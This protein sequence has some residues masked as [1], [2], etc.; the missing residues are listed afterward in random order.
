M[1]A[2][3]S[4]G[5]GSTR[6]TPSIFLS[7]RRTARLQEAQV[8][9]STGMMTFDSPTAALAACGALPAALA[10]TTATIPRAEAAIRTTR[11]WLMALPRSCTL[12]STN[13]SGMVPQAGRSS[14]LDLDAGKNR[15]LQRLVEGMV[16]E[17][18]VERL[19]VAPRFHQAV[20]LELGQVLRDRGH[21]H[22][23]N[24]GD[25][26]DADLLH[27]GEQPGDAQAG[28]TS[29]DREPR[30]ELVNLGRE[31]HLLAQLGDVLRSQ[32]GSHAFH[33]STLTIAHA[34]VSRS[35]ASCAGW[36]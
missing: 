11:R 13:E 2:S 10:G 19:R 35:S 23:E 27:L 26:A 25:V 15:L 9:P 33:G 8:S 14:R 12:A 20:R 16:G 5:P 36:R 22:T 4:C 17:R 3:F 7:A 21:G 32:R 6:L 29:G 30:R 1:R 31:L 28:R 34:S 18:I 24:L